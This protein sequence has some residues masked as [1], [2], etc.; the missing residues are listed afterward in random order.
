M[1]ILLGRKGAAS[2]GALAGHLESFSI[3]FMRIFEISIVV[4]LM[5]LI[6]VAFTVAVQEKRVIQD[7][8]QLKKA[9][10]ISP[11][12]LVS[13]PSTQSH[14]IVTPVRRGASNRALPSVPH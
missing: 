4:F 6:G 10:S 1:P 9:E 7:L 14:S 2:V 12:T 5:L 13:T 3:L 8:Y 11:R